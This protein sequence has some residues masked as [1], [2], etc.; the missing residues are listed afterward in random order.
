MGGGAI[1]TCIAYYLVKKHQ[2]RVTIVDPS[3]PNDGLPFTPQAASGRAGGFL[4]KEWCNGQET[5]ALT[6]LSYALHQELSFLDSDYRV[7]QTF[8][9]TKATVNS[10]TPKAVK[11]PKKCTNIQHVVPFCNLG[12]FD[13]VRQSGDTLNC[14]Q[15]TPGKFVKALQEET[16]RLGSLTIVRGRVVG[17]G[18]STGDGDGDGT[19]NGGGTGGGEKRGLIVR[20]NT[21]DVGETSTSSATSTVVHLECTDFVVAAGPW[22]NECKNWGAPFSK[23]PEVEG[24][25]A[26]SVVYDVGVTEAVALFVGLSNGSEIEYYPRPDGTVY[27]CGEGEDDSAVVQERP[28]FVQTVKGKISTLKTNSSSL[29]TLFNAGKVQ[30]ESACHLPVVISSTGLPLLC[31]IEKGSR[32]YIATGHTCWGICQ[33]PGT[34]LVMAELIAGKEPSVCL[35]KFSIPTKDP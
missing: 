13:N 25:K 3:A 23:L 21:S 12:H 9:A 20:V 14:A 28:G 10:T 2:C 17:V 19:G 4:A 18:L 27:V 7:L 30:S 33:A 8:S 31:E 11:K 15:V 29:S 24:L 26:H 5:E 16:M 6:K 1:G 22:S 34:G 35:E 32:C